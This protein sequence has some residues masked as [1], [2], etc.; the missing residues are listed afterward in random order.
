MHWTA[1]A[2]VLLARIAS[3]SAFND[4]RQW[5]IQTTVQLHGAD[6]I[7]RDHELRIPCCVDVQREGVKF[8]E[9]GDLLPS[10]C[11]L[12]KAYL[13]GLQEGNQAC[14][15]PALAPHYVPKQLK[16]L[17][18]DVQHATRQRIY[19]QLSVFEGDTQT[20]SDKIPAVC[21]QFD[22]DVD[23][24]SQFA[25]AYTQQVLDAEV[26]HASDQLVALFPYNPQPLEALQRV[27]AH[28]QSAL[29]DEQRRHQQV[30]RAYG[31]LRLELQLQKNL[32]ATALATDKAKQVNSSPLIATDSNAE[33][34]G[35]CT[36]AMAGIK[37]TVPTIPGNSSSTTSVHDSIK[38]IPIRRFDS[39]TL[40][41]AEYR[42]LATHSVP[43]ILTHAKMLPFTPGVPPWSLHVLNATCGTRSAVL[44][45]QCPHKSTWAG[46][47]SVTY[48]ALHEFLY[49]IHHRKHEPWPKSLSS[50]YLHDESVT[51]FCPDLLQSFVIPK[52]FARDALQHTCTKNTRY[53]PSLFVG[54]A[55]TSSGL[56]VDWGATSAWMGL[57]QGRKRWRIAPPS[58]RPFLYEQPGA[59]GKFDAD[60][61]APNMTAFPLLRHVPVYDGVLEAGEVMFIP[62][63]CPHQV[64][65]LELSVA[66]AMNLVDHANIDAHTRH[67]RHQLLEAAGMG[68]SAVAGQYEHVLAS[69]ETTA[70]HWKEDHD[71]DEP[72]AITFADFKQ[73]SICRH[74]FW[75]V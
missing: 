22:L 67:V 44:K 6:G 50:L 56:H 43:F 13:M 71:Q 42:H 14:H 15:C 46:I 74:N 73:T 70:R 17:P 75:I 59:D 47:E 64:V 55:R 68:H 29:A 41:Y 57:V 32:H 7:T 52:Y 16:S 60:L 26:A 20:L 48:A 53:W 63:D 40:S 31:A 11:G 24:C 2:V 39:R 35:S 72:V 30:S 12:F 3:T 8:C 54:D 69:L 65:N 58:A 10:E 18:F 66:V 49:D 34:Q 21:T 5:L 25:A 33:V 62:A 4:P 38:T 36:A 23:S 61:M 51:S 27:I 28:L 1:I 45:H 19:F 9:S 37:S